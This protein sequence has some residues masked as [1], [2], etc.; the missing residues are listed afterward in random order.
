M[1]ID[2]TWRRECRLL[3]VSETGGKLLVEQSMV[4]LNLED[5]FSRSFVDKRGIT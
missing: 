3:D 2:G 5:L 4:G 1:A